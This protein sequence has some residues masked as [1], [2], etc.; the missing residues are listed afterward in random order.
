MLSVYIDNTGSMIEMDKIEVAKY[1]AYNLKAK[2]HTLK[3]EEIQNL[4]SITLENFNDINIESNDIKILLSD[5]LFDFKIEE[6]IFDIALAI[7]LDSNKGILAP[8][9]L[10]AAL[11]WRDLSAL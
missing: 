6:K 8:H 9:R 4:D 10:S 11:S 3:G 7:G 2:Y 5:G 1:V